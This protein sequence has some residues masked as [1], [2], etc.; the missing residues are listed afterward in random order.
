MGKRLALSDEVK[1]AIIRLRGQG[2]KPKVISTRIAKDYGV[3]ISPWNVW[4]ITRNNIGR[5]P[6]AGKATRRP[7][8]TRRLVNSITKMIQELDKIHQE[9]IDQY[10]K[11]KRELNQ[12]V[13]AL[14]AKWR[15]QNAMKEAEGCDGTIGAGESAGE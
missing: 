3:T 4:N 5:K 15:K 11:E 14:I 10:N 12:S 7:A 6:A 9:T 13:I 2:V 1:A 8:K